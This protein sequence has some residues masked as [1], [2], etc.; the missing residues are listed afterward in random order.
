MILS[1]VIPVYNKFNFTQA[2]LSDLSKLPEDHQ[3]IV[4]DNGSTDETQQQL[5]KN[6]R[7]IYLRQ[8][9]NLGFAKACN[10]GYSVS[11]APNV[12]FLNNDIRIKSNYQNWTDE[13]VK[14]CPSALVGP[15]MGQLDN[16]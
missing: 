5:E 9:A 4:V 15:T 6:S 10:L 11:T 12:L 7:I 2:C 13:L 8:S 14:W 3:I 1:I 16:Q